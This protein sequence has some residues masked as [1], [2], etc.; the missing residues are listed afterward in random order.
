MR[1]EK[2]RKLKKKIYVIYGGSLTANLSQNSKIFVHDFLQKK[3][4]RWLV[5]F[6]KIPQG[7]DSCLIPNKIPKKSHV[8]HVITI[9]KLHFT[10]P[11]SRNRDLFQNCYLLSADLIKLC[12]F[13]VFFLCFVLGFLPFSWWGSWRILIV[14][15]FRGIW[16][17]TL[18]NLSYVG[19][20]FISRVSISGAC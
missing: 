9:T 15:V 4:F 12:D 6:F 10:G 17:G 19:F 5:K 11:N 18:G 16:E 20:S 8:R 1:K 2:T 7:K 3:K 13:M 14:R